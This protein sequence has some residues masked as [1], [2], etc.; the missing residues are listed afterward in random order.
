M[1]KAIDPNSADDNEIWKMERSASKVLSGDSKSVKNNRRKM[2]EVNKYTN[3][4]TSPEDKKWYKDCCNKLE[5]VFNTIDR[6][7][8]I[9][10]LNYLL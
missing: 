2:V 3:K 1:C 9:D 6:S 7:F 10:I 4:P 8:S 5:S